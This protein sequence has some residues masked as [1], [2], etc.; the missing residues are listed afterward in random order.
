MHRTHTVSNVTNFKREFYGGFV[1]GD[2]AYY[3]VIDSRPIAAQ[4]IRLLR[5]CNMPDCGGPSTCGVAAFELG[6]GSKEVLV[7]VECH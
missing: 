2:F 7:C 5:I 3:V 6:F 1:S 4:A